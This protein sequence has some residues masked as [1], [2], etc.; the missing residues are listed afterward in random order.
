MLYKVP[1]NDFEII[2][3]HLIVFKIVYYWRHIAVPVQECNAMK[4]KYL[5]NSLAHNNSS[6][7]SPLTIHY[8]VL[9]LF[10]G[11]DIAALMAWKLTVKMVMSNDPEIAT[12]KIHQ[13]RDVL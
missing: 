11:F 9:K 3:K 4:A 6:S 2:F 13:L 8:S 7:H 5:F 12:A 1:N 10:T